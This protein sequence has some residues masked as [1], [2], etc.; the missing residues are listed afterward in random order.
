MT[1][2]SKLNTLT[3]PLITLAIPA[4]TL[5]KLSGMEHSGVV[6]ELLFAL[7]FLLVWGMR[8][9]IR[10][11][12]I[13]LSAIPKILFVLGRGGGCLLRTQLKPQT[14]P[15]TAFA[16]ATGQRIRP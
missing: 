6:Q 13:S 8:D 5:M 11:K 1:N 14:E 4:L 10:R 7:T 15:Q 2:T 9:V 3:E 16:T 12:K